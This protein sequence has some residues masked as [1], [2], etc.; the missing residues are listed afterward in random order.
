MKRV[1]VWLAIGWTTLTLSAQ[2]ATDPGTNASESPATPAESVVISEFLAA[3]VTGLRDEDGDTSDWIELA[4]AGTNLVNLGGWFLTDDPGNLTK[5][6]FPAVSLSGGGYLLVFASGKDR[7]KPAAPLH[8]NFRLARAGE[9]LGLVDAGTNVVSEFA[10][11]FP[12]QQADTSYGP[13]EPLSPGASLR[14]GS[15]RVHRSVQQDLYRAIIRRPRE[16]TVV[17]R[18]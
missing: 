8:T 9:Y 14:R 10:P 12:P 7:A 2:S 4:N 13:T 3:N 11:T 5:W 16:R 15:T 17:D 18:G 6:R 1:M